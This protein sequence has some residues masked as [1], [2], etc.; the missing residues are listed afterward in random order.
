MFKK[1]L[2]PFKIL[3]IIVI[4][5]IIVPHSIFPSQT[6]DN[7][8]IT[9]N[10]YIILNNKET[11][12]SDF[13]DDEEALKLKVAQLS[14]INK[15]RKKNRVPEVKL[16]ILACRVA[17]KMCKEAAENQYLSHWN[18]AGEKPYHR[19]A[20]AGGNDHVSENA[21]G[22]STTGMFAHSSQ[23][24]ADM[25]KQ[26]HNSFM[27]ERAPADGHRKNIIEKSHNFVGIGYYL[28]INQ[29]RYYEEFIDRY[30]EFEN[31]TSE[32]RINETSS[33][34]LNT[35][36]KVFPF[37]MIIYSE[38]KPAP[39]SPGQLNRKGSY[40]D[41]SDQEYLSVPAWDLAKYRKGSI[42]RIPVSFS[43][44]GLYYIQIFTD[45]KEIINPV[46]LSTKGKTIS[47][48]IVIKVMK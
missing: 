22:E 24:I 46:K 43:R 19:Y 11:R 7:D 48:G 8:S 20:F 4:I 31:V 12:L 40:S 37:F 36:G 26:G 9:L 33:I 10:D 2:R 23:T 21:Y 1:F 35:N 25:M 30:L 15:S 16:D 34:T 32:L 38:P 47:S 3:F 13:K 39:M 45:K 28:T 27:A 29:F 42:Y 41:F 18:L 14:V 6:S 44:E 17:N 5:I